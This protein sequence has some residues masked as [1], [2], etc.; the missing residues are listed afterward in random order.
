MDD[1]RIPVGDGVVLRGDGCFEALRSYEGVPFAMGPHLDRLERSAAALRI[2]VPGR[3]LVEAWVEQVA[4]LGGNGIVRVLLTRGGVIP[5]CD[6]PPRCIVLHHALP[7][8]LSE[9]GVLPVVSPWHSAGRGW[10]LAGAKTL[11]YAPNQAASRRAEE[12]GFDD[13]LLISDQGIVLEGPTFSIGWVRDGVLETPGLDLL[14]LDSITRRLVLEDARRLGIRVDEGAFPLERLESADEAM[15]WS[16]TKE[17][18]PV[19]RVGEHR[20]APGPMAARLSVAFRERV[21]RLAARPGG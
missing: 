8:R 12:Q 5:G 21:G 14:I 16:T 4:R 13:A 18:K 9:V 11:S 1:P 3:G 17:V 20:F 2:E 15:A 19:T 7:P 10:D 6:E